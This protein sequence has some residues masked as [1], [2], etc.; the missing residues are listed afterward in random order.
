MSEFERLKRIIEKEEKNT[1]ALSEGQDGPVPTWSFSTLK[2]FEQC[3]YRVYLSK[4]GKVPVEQ[5]RAAARGNQV[6]DAAEA[7]VTGQTEELAKELAKFDVALG[8]LKDKYSEGNIEVEQEWGFNKQWEP[9]SWYASDIWGKM[10]LDVFVRDDSDSCVIIDYKT[11]RRQG[12]EIKH[13]DQGIVY[14]IGAMMRYPEIKYAQVEFW[15]IDE[16]TRLIKSYTKDQVLYLIPNFERRAY[17]LT[18]CKDFPPRPSTFTCKW[19]SHR[20]T[21]SCDYAEGA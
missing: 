12:N 9:C 15:Y 1:A 20:A 11:G 5:G 7:Y 4:I 17:R 19:C 6:H 10:K 16:G 2:D 21:D 8:H 14:T 13:T 3:P 18:T